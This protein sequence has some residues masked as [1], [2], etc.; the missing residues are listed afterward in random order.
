M[1]CAADGKELARQ[2]Q[3]AP[4]R[5]GEAAHP[6]RLAYQCA[7]CPGLCNGVKMIAQRAESKEPGESKGDFP[8]SFLADPRPGGYRA[9][10]GK[11]PGYQTVRFRS[12]IWESISSASR[13]AGRNIPK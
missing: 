2:H 11:T 13:I 3:G 12:S 5:Y 8:G 7:G 6:R 9:S 4:Q 10:R 1:N